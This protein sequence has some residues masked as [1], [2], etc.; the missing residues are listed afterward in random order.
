LEFVL[1]RSRS[2]G[3]V[4]RAVAP[5]ILGLLPPAAFADGIGLP[6]P[7]RLEVQ[8]AQLARDIPGS[9][10]ALNPLRNDQSAVDAAGTRFTLTSLNPA[11]NHW[12]VLEIAPAS[13]RAQSVHLESGD[14]EGTRLSLVGGDDPALRIDRDGEVFDCRPWAD[15]A[16]EEA[17]ASDLPFAPVCDWS[18]FVRNPVRGNRTTREA[19]SQF[20]RDN[21]IFGD[22]IVNLI[23][24]AFYEDAF[25][26]S[27]EGIEAE[28]DIDGVALLGTARLDRT[29]QIRPYWGFDLVGDDAGRVT[30]GSWYEIEDAPG[31]YASAMQPGMIAR[32]IFDV[33]GANGLDGVERNADVYLVAF[34]LT[35]FELG[36]EIGTDHPGLEWSSRPSGAG[37]HYQAP[38][39]DGFD[40]PDPLVFTGMLSPNLYDRVAATFT[41]GFKRDHGAWRFGQWA[42]F[43]WGNHYGFL[44]H[45]VLFSRLWP[46]LATLY[47]TTE[48]EVGMGTWTEA[49][50]ARQG[51]MVFARQ[52][53]VPL[54]ENGVP[55]SQVTSWGGGNWSG[56]AEAQL[57]TLRGG[58]CMR[59]IGG[60][61]FLIYAYFSS[62]TPSGMA[63]TFQAYDCD[64]AMLLDMNSQELTYL[65]VYTRDG[66]EIETR[67][68]VSGMA[69]ADPRG[70]G[71][72]VPRFIAAPDNRDFFYLVRPEE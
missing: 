53:G 56:S 10:F 12:F 17:R 4:L 61:P 36:Y 16:L 27:S 30:A 62:V 5:C 57:R 42:T 46:G 23:K 68:L 52:N 43:N 18:L 67:H 64:Y 55:G 60:R 8:Q 19:V 59:Q 44:S 34:D 45:G 29:P 24:G 20:L 51:E 69:E 32:A 6:D 25:M 41:G 47:V 28:E 50:A 3:S 9:V 31:I 7:A 63:R 37:R 15:G 40:R 66:D 33:P 14:A 71:G 72:A 49:D 35:R 1:P 70:S 21:V 38:G 2:F 26:V 54:I 11:V 65:A 39:P 48:G 22:S 13:G 58:A